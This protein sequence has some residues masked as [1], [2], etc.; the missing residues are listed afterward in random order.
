MINI[1]C[2]IAETQEIILKKRSGILSLYVITESAK[3]PVYVGSKFKRRA[4]E[5]INK[6][7]DFKQIQTDALQREF[8]NNSALKPEAS[9]Q[10]PSTITLPEAES[11]AENLEAHVEI[12]E[13]KT[14]SV[15]FAEYF[16]EPPVVLAETDSLKQSSEVEDLENPSAVEYVDTAASDV[17]LEALTEIEDS[18]LAF[19]S[20]FVIPEISSTEFEVPNID[21]E[22]KSAAKETNL[23]LAELKPLAL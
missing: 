17:P 13:E 15:D 1:A 2:S 16:T 14:A 10:E 5:L 9:N 21:E 6:F 12:A 19:E 23:E 11:T 18:Q 22:P 20:T 8:H 4:K 3:Y 7:N